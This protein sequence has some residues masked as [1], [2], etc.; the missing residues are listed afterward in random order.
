[1]QPRRHGVGLVHHAELGCSTQVLQ[2]G[3]NSDS[4]HIGASSS[5]CK[6]TVKFPNIL[7]KIPSSIACSWI[8]R[9]RR[10]VTCE[11]REAG[12]ALQVKKY[13]IKS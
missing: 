5:G 6:Q 12:I 10:R 9:L 13:A 1:M 2:A 4:Y 8:K 3:N 11:T 7:R